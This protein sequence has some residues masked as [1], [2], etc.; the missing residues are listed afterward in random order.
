MATPSDQQH[1][2]TPDRP[3][4]RRNR[5]SKFLMSLVSSKSRPVSPDMTHEHS[6]NVIQ[7]GAR[8]QK[9]P[10]LPPDHPHNSS[11][12]VLGERQYNAQPQP[13]SP[14]KRTEKATGTSRYGSRSPTK[15]DSTRMKRSKSSTSISAIF[16]KMNRSTET[17]RTRRN[18]SHSHM[19][20]RTPHLQTRPP[21]QSTLRFGHSLPPQ[22][23]TS[24]DPRKTTGR[25]GA[26]KTRLTDTHPRT[27]RL[28][29]N[30]TSTAPQPQGS[31]V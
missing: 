2:S 10:I 30:A 4:H 22:R 25:L 20:K 1:A 24:L 21:S 13:S 16:G 18:S 5:S 28:V 17:S 14:S 6:S 11:A 31:P 3:Q 29:N 7:H 23:R 26:S 19:G 27:T 15:T 9:I 12:R 8:S